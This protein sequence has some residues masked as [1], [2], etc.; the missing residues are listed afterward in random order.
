M[1]QTTRYYDEFLKY[2]NLAQKQQDLCN[3]GSV[4]HAESGLGD[5][6]MEYVELYDVVERKY[7]G[8]SQIINDCFYGWSEDHPYWNKMKAGQ[9][10]RQRETVAKD[11]TGRQD[12]Y[13]LPE[14]LYVFI[15]HRVTGSAINYAQKPSGYYNTI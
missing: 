13:S 5:D 15:L 6:L 12:V 9:C 2:F 10:T 3:L 7:A 11:W 1:I 4:P 8:F 14:W